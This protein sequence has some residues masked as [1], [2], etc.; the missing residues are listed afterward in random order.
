MLFPALQHNSHSERLLV[1]GDATSDTRERMASPLETG[2]S[3]CHRVDTPCQCDTTTG[4]IGALA[5]NLRRTDL[6]Q[7]L[8]FL[9]VES[10]GAGPL[11]VRL[12][13]RIGIL[14]HGDSFPTRAN[15]P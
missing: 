3:D 8:D 13:S 2:E 10:K 5:P 4:D 12:G 9:K 15:S 1:L 6:E 14:Q 7:L 11:D